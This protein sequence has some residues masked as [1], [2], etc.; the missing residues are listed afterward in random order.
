ML[1]MLLL[2]TALARNVMRSVVSV[3]PFLFPLCLFSQL[4]FE[5]FDVYYELLL[6]VAGD[7]KSR[8]HRSRSKTHVCAR[9][10]STTGVLWV[11]IDCR[12]SG[13]PLWCYLLRASAARRAAWRGWGQRQ[14]Q[15]ACGCGNVVGLTSILEQGQFFSSY[16]AIFAVCTV[17]LL[18]VI[19][20]E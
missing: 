5:L 19:V 10:I 16:Y 6:Q 1:G 8:T 7:W 12:S 17:N 2:P 4:T 3:R 15:G 13:F 14:R 18:V 11:L 9:L 20:I